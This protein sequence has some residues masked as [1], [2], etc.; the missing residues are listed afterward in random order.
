MGE[1]HLHQ[2]RVS[3]GHRLLRWGQL[4]RHGTTSA[5]SERKRHSL[6]LTGVDGAAAGKAE[7]IRVDSE[8]EA[9][10]KSDRPF[11]GQ[12]QRGSRRDN[13]RTVGRNGHSARDTLPSRIEHH[14]TETAGC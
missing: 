1:E 9:A 11:Q 13:G 12:R 2:H 7:G 6:S 4:P 3:D 10:P 14:T 8:D 5:R